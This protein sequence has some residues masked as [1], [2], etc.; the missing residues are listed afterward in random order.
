MNEVV[1]ALELAQNQIAACREKCDEHEGDLWDTYQRA[2][3]QA[4]MSVP[5]SR[6]TS[7][8]DSGMVWD[9][10]TD[11][12]LETAQEMHEAMLTANKEVS[13]ER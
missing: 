13:R 2:I 9:S 11:T 3:D 5:P 12:W 1:H 10:L 7:D 4:K 6:F 8:P